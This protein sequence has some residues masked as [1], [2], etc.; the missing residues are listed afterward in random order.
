MDSQQYYL[1]LSPPSSTD[2]STTSQSSMVWPVLWHYIEHCTLYFC[3]VLRTSK[4]ASFISILL[5]STKSNFY[6]SVRDT[7]I[8]I[9]D[10]TTFVYPNV[11]FH[12][13]HVDT[14]LNLIAI[15]R[16]HPMISSNLLPN[17][18][19]NFVFQMVFPKKSCSKCTY[20]YCA[21]L[22][23]TSS[24]HS[25]TLALSNITFPYIG[26]CRS[27]NERVVAALRIPTHSPKS[28]LPLPL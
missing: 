11:Y 2:S 8:Q 22:F 6:W 3:I 1:P 12:P 23:R 17:S 15:E 4:S 21:V 7:F 27:N 16:Y 18:L 5:G 20:Y 28:V 9:I 13:E 10:E 19:S 14:T 24:F 25:Y 26:C